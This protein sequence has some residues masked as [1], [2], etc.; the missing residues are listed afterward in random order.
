MGLQAFIVI[1][2]CRR[3]NRVIALDYLS[4]IAGG[5]EMMMH[6]AV[7][8]NKPFAAGLFHCAHGH[9]VKPGIGGEIS[10][11]VQE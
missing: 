1:H 7:G 9:D 8:H 10:G 2:F 3:D 4:E 5:G 11:P 6:A